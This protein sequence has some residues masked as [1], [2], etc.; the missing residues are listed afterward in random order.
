MKSYKCTV[1][2]VP[3]EYSGEIVNSIDFEYDA[4]FAFDFVAGELNYFFCKRCKSKTN[5]TEPVLFINKSNKE[6]IIFFNVDNIDDFVDDIKKEASFGFDKLEDYTIFGINTY[7]DAAQKLAFW[8]IN[9]LQDFFATYLSEEYYNKSALQKSKVINKIVLNYFAL[10]K[11][12]LLTIQLPS[13]KMTPTELFFEILSDKIDLIYKNCVYE[14]N[15][16]TYFDCLTREIPNRCFTE[17]F[18]NYF[19]NRFQPIVFSENLNREGYYKE[20]NDSFKRELTISCLSNL[21]KVISGREKLFSTIIISFWYQREHDNV[22]IDDNYFL[23]ST[24]AS[25]TLTFEYLWNAIISLP[26]EEFEYKFRLA[27]KVSEYY[28]F[29]DKFNDLLKT[30]NVLKANI[31]DI[32]VDAFYDKLVELSLNE[33]SLTTENYEENVKLGYTLS[34]IVKNAYDSTKNIDSAFDLHQKLFH[35]EK[36]KS[37]IAKFVFNYKTIK[38]LNNLQEYSKSKNLLLSSRQFPTGLQ[39][40]EIISYFIEEGNT[41]RYFGKKKEALA[42]YE[43]AEAQISSLTD[44]ERVKESKL[45]LKRNKLIIFRDLGLFSDAINEFEKLLESNENENED[46]AEILHNIAATYIQINNYEKAI[47]YLIRALNTISELDYRNYCNYSVSLG[48]A[49]FKNGQQKESINCVVSAFEK[50]EDKSS[51]ILL[52]LAFIGLSNFPKILENEFTE[53]RNEI[54]KILKSEIFESKS[55]HLHLRYTATIIYGTFLI[56]CEEFNKAEELLTN[57]RNDYGK[58]DNWKYYYLSAWVNMQKFEF[59]NAWID[60]KESINYFKKALPN[61][62]VTDFLQDIDTEE[63]QIKISDWAFNLFHQNVVTEFDLIDIFEFINGYEITYKLALKFDF[64]TEIN[65]DALYQNEEYKD[66]DFF[67]FYDTTKTTHLLYYNAYERKAVV[68]TDFSFDIEEVS[69]MRS[70]LQRNFKNYVQPKVSERNF[71]FWNDFQKDLGGLISK[72]AQG[73][74]VCLFLG[75]TFSNI[76]LTLAKI[77]DNEYLIERYNVV[78]GINLTSFILGGFFDEYSIA[79]STIINVH[80]ENDDSKFRQNISSFI[81]DITSDGANEFELLEGINATKNN[82]LNS[83]ASSQEVLFLCHGIDGNIAISNGE[84]LPPSDYFE[85]V[86]KDFFLSY[87]DF[88]SLEK[89]PSLVVSAACSS[90]SL[91]HGK[92]GVILGLGQGVWSKGTNSL[93][94][95]QWD[96]DQE[97]GFLWLKSFYSFLKD[98]KE[99]VAI[100]HKKATLITKEK[101]EYP[102]Y[103]SPFVLF[104]N[105]KTLKK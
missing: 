69:K 7:L 33:S 90:A 21:C 42:S 1:C 102:F 8:C 87:Q 30:G 39:P 75:E 95:P 82:I 58:I 48:L 12:N 99:S 28:G 103:W 19:T 24:L 31:S 105:I 60:I 100:A 88:D 83:F 52:R 50:I 13:K 11:V 78:N 27:E 45:V 81:S 40:Y 47:K 23:N 46:N 63:F 37:D 17:D 3:N 73:N 9:P 5:I 67:F 18:F 104:G 4:D 35:S 92:G 70:K 68:E 98:S 34:L 51:N 76:P 57:L 49:F 91:K 89:S 38:L 86:L 101:C 74:S 14:K 36:I 59:Y 85:G 79:N 44:E 43:N 6:I 29:E 10:V 96:I 16:S 97:A 20:L 56:R 65:Y 22:Q 72:Y 84:Y 71:A 53:I 25:K 62:K 54:I 80:K 93:I 41:H 15:I 2:N 77:T 26:N 32:K 66:I 55:G 61:Q 64:E 94:C